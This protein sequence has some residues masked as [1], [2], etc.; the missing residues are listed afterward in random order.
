[1]L[2][3]TITVICGTNLVTGFAL[4]G[5]EAIGAETPEKAGRIITDLHNSGNWGIVLVADDI[6]EKLTDREQSRMGTSTDPVFIRIPVTVL[7]DQDDDRVAREIVETM[8]QKA[9]GRKIAIAGN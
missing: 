6:A 5:V 9:I 3:A 7:P 8:L 1:M 4:S 2:K